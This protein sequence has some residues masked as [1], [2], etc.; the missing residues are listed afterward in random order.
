M[1]YL[2]GSKLAT[3]IF[4]YSG[5]RRKPHP[6]SARVKTSPVDSC[7]P[8]RSGKTE[9]TLGQLTWRGPLLTCEATAHVALRAL[10]WAGRAWKRVE[11]GVSAD[12]EAYQTT[13]RMT[14]EQRHCAA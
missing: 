2:I 5:G 14:A 6:V 7:V 9:R 13:Y 1:L 10:L 4:G 3:F 8:T 12:G 11:A